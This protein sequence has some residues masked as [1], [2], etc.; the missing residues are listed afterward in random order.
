M[1]EGKS[2]VVETATSTSSSEESSLPGK[3]RGVGWTRK[4]RTR[5]KKKRLTANV[6][7]RRNRTRKRRK[8][9]R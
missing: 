1:T 8:R 5:G 4:L 6:S 7:R 2:E 9:K 3:K